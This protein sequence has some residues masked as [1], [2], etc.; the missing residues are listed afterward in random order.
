[1]RVKN[2]E[3]QVKAYDNFGVVP[4]N[5]IKIAPPSLLVALPSLHF[6]IQMLV[7]EGSGWITSGGFFG[8]DIQGSQVNVNVNA[9]YGSIQVVLSLL[10]FLE[11]YAED[12]V[13][14]QRNENGHTERKEEKKLVTIL[15]RR[16]PLPP[17][18]QLAFQRFKGF[19]RHAC[20]YTCITIGGILR[21]IAEPPL[22]IDSRPPHH[23]H[24][25]A[26]NTYTHTPRRTTTSSPIPTTPTNARARTQEPN[27]A[28]LSERTEVPFSLLCSSHLT[29][30]RH[31]HHDRC[32]GR[33]AHRDRDRRGRKR[34][35]EEAGRGSRRTIWRGCRLTTSG[36][37]F[38]RSTLSF[39]IFS[40]PTRRVRRPIVR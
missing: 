31:H 8:R 20:M 11:L 24:H 10:F 36:F 35:L 40:G 2:A 4:F 16:Q 28:R 37:A 22:N 19:S 12:G 7:S 9:V 13:R 14:V 5:N 39:L 1:M 38:H 32:L 15:P 27:T 18:L 26:S 23:H 21:N 17:P 29:R 3:S 34:V 6:R 25:H 30:R 33:R